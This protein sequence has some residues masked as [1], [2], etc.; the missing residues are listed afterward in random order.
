MEG[1][2]AMQILYDD[3]SKRTSISPQQL[4]MHLHWVQELIETEK[5][6]II[7]AYNAEVLPE[8]YKNGETYYNQT[9]N[10]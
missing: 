2:T 8:S 9:Y 5:Q 4:E 3:L 7:D 1:K 10:Q 6:Q